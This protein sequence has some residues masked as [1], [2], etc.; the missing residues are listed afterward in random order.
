METASHGYLSLDVSP[1]SLS[2]RLAHAPA[3]MLH[4]VTVGVAPQTV[5][6]ESNISKLYDLELIVTIIVYN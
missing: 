5:T 2:L 3:L 1:P 4:R 6:T